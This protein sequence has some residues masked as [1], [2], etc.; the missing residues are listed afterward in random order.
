MIN[1]EQVRLEFKK[2]VNDY[3]VSD[4]KIAL[5]IKHTYKVS[6]LCDDIAKSNNMSDSD[7]DLAWLIGMLHDIG[8]FEQCRIYDTFNDS[9]S[10]DHA[11]YGCQILFSEK[12]HDAEM[13]EKNGGSL[14]KRFCTDEDYYDVIH[15]TIHC[16]NEYKIP[17]EIEADQRKRMFATILRDADKIDIIRANNETP[18]EEI[19]NCTRE[20][21]MSSDITDEVLEVVLNHRTVLKALK[22]T[23][24]DNLAG[25]ISLMYELEHKRSRELAKELG[26]LETML[27]FKS[28]N[29]NTNKKLAIIRNEMHKYMK[30]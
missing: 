22:K 28:D 21:V 18:L 12:Y 14:I 3:N 19:Y 4:P 6:E 13:T 1:R 30:W 20:E 29:D 5:K 8:R 17:E 23:P 10:V 11:K 27:N 9:L 7:V 16:H 25:H 2:Y 15:D 24:I 26:Y